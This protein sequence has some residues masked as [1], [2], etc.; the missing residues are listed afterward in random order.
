M[1]IDAVFGLA[2]AFAPN[3]GWLVALRFLTGLGVGGTLP[4][5]YAMLAEFLPADRRGR[6]LVALEGFWAIGTVVLALA[7]LA[8]QGAHP[9]DI[10]RILFAATAAPALMGLGLRLLIPESPLFL[11]RRDRTS[12]ANAVL[13]KIARR[14]DG[15]AV[16]RTCWRPRDRSRHRRP[17]G[18]FSVRI[19]AGARR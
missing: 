14:T 17:P 2:S 6:W 7:S 12:E 1:L 9:A 5:D 18:R 13:A 8:A 16:R 3:F 4:V 15:P 19:F 11:L 10:W